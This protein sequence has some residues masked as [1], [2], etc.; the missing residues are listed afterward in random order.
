MQLTYKMDKVQLNFLQLLS[1]EAS[2]QFT[3][4]CLNTVGYYS[5]DNST[6]EQAVKFLTSDDR[7]LS[8]HGSTKYTYNTI[9]D[10]CQVII[11]VPSQSVVK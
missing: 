2:Q 3:L 7:E 5:S 6:S 1:E 9:S 4:G 11:S 10:S 8:P